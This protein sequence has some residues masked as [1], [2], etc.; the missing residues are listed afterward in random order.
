MGNQRFLFRQFQLEFFAQKG[1][2]SV[3]DLF[4]L[5]FGA[6]EC[7][8]EVVGVSALLE[9]SVVGVV[10]IDGGKFLRLSFALLSGLLLPALP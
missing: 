5:C 1:S 2:E 7:Q 6:N 10:G 4:C 3:F 9:S 8:S